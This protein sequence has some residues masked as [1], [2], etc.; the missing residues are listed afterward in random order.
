[1]EEVLRAEGERLPAHRGVEQQLLEVELEVR[2]GPE[3][4]AEPGRVARRVAGHRGPPATAAEPGWLVV[5]LEVERVR[6][7]VRRGEPRVEEEERAEAQRERRRHLPG[8]PPAAPPTAATASEGEVR[9][10]GLGAR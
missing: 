1:M 5:W 6:G 3:E 10:P 7:E 9:R 4:W 2:R 8:A